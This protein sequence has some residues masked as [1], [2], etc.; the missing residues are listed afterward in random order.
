MRTP[1]HEPAQA[2]PEAPAHAPPLALLGAPPAF[3]APLHVGRPNIGDRARFM[4]RV[5]RIL[6]SFFDHHDDGWWRRHVRST[7]YGSAGARQ[8][9][10][11]SA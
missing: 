3:E 2:G 8:R 4:A 11:T 6:E 10:S 9:G 1:P 5:E 7:P